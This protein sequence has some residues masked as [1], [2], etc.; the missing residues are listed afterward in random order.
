[1]PNMFITGA[2]RG[3]GLEFARQYAAEG[4][5]V[6]AAC[7]SPESANDLKALNGV[8]VHKLDVMDH[9]AIDRLAAELNI[10]FDV[11]IANAGVMGPRGDDQSFGTLNYGAWRETMEVNVYGAV[12]TCEAFTPHLEQ[13]DQKK[14][15]VITSKMGSIADT[16]SGYTIYRTSKTALNMAMVAAAPV[17]AQKDIAVGI[18][19]PGWVQTDM[20][21]ENALISTEQCVKGLREQIEKTSPAEQPQFLTYAGDVVPW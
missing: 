2:N 13:G 6:H 15:A 21:G 4:W 14:M 5:N 3:I 18:F 8:T 19:H 10:P 12:R 16:S 7:R 17:L 1:M 9:A 20:G 11:V